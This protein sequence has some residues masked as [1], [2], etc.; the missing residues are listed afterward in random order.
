MEHLQ[1]YVNLILTALTLVFAIGVWKGR[2]DF[3]TSDIIKKLEELRLEAQQ[4]LLAFKTDFDKYRERHH[5]SIDN[6]QSILGSLVTT[7]EVDRL[8]R[9]SEEEHNRLWREIDTLRSRLGE[10]ERVVSMRRELRDGTKP[11]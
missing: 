7:K 9:Q 5:R 6:L 1:Q 8:L 11:K 10:L 3:L 2:K 4:D